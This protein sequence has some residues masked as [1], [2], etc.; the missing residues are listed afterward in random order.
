MDLVGM[1][2]PQ[3]QFNLPT[4]L[5]RGLH[6]H[7]IVIHVHNSIERLSSYI[8]ALLHS[9]ANWLTY[10]MLTTSLVAPLYVVKGH[11]ICKYLR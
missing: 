1:L 11:Y 10:E 6:V 8:H 3:A 2:P 9:K 5:S 7:L 4:W